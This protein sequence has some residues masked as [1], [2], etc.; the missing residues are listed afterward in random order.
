MTKGRSPNTHIN[1]S[2]QRTYS[3]LC[4]NFITFTFKYIPSEEN[5]ADPLSRRELGLPQD[6]MDLSFTLPPELKPIFIYAN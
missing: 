6:R 1:L 5:P 3:V 2:I 4:P